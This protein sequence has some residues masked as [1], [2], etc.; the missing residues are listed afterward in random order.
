MWVVVFGMMNVAV[1]NMIIAIISSDTIFSFPCSSASPES[2]HHLLRFV[3]PHLH[4]C[5]PAA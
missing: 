3:I 5:V 4:G 1:I 2:H